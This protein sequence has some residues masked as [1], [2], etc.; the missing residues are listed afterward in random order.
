M[1]GRPFAIALICVACGGM[2]A[3]PT[4]ETTTFA[5]SLG[6]NLAASTKTKDGEYYR[7][8]VAGTAATVSAGQTLSVHYTGWLTNGAIFDTNL[9]AAAF[10]FRLGAGQVIAGWD[11]G[12]VGARV[13]GTRQLVIPPALGYGASGYAQ[14]PPNAILV[15]TVQVDSAQ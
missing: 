13:G 12:L 7:D 15:F 11:E 10:S 5:N 2:D 9:G 4:I 8:L 14:I 6:V 1:M 3:V